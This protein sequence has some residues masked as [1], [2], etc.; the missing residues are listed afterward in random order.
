MMLYFAYGFYIEYRLDNYNIINLQF[1]TTR[2][3]SNILLINFIIFFTGH[4]LLRVIKDDIQGIYYKWY[5]IIVTYFCF[6]RLSGFIIIFGLI[7][8]E[9]NLFDSLKMCITDLIPFYCDVIFMKLDYILHFNNHPWVFFLPILTSAI[10]AKAIDLLYASWYFAVNIFIFWLS[11]SNRRK[12]RMQFFMT[13]ILILFVIGNFMATILSSAGPCYYEKVTRY[14][15]NNPFRPLME[16]LHTINNDIPL[17]A[18]ELQGNLWKNYVKKGRVFGNYISAMPSVHV[19]F[20]ALFALTLSAINI[21]L[22][23]VGWAYWLV[24]LI[25]SVILGWHYALDGYFATLITIAL[26]KLSGYFNNWF[27]QEL[28]TKVQSQIFR[29]N[30]SIL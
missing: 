7:P 3:I 30:E 1:D 12:L 18:V 24:I 16:K 22:G 14:T 11:W 2:L 9:L 26:W 19:A 23:I 27:W 5:D 20:A 6:N 25:G 10:A 29:P 8:I 21:Y 15:E 4:F 28:P 13:N 17:V